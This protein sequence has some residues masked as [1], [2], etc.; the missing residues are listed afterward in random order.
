[1]NNISYSRDERPNFQI[2]MKLY[3]T[4]IH[5]LQEF[6]ANESIDGA[7]S[8]K[9]LILYNFVT[10]CI[11]SEDIQPEL[12]RY[13]LPFYL[14]SMEQAVIYENHD[15]LQKTAMDIYFEFNDAMFFNQK[16]FKYAVGE[17][18]YQYIMEYY[19]SQTL[20]KMEIQNC[21]M[22][23]WVSLFNTTAALDNNNIRRLFHE[24]FKGSLKIKYS[25]F[26]YLSILLF[27]EN[28]N[29]LAINETQEFWTSHIWDFDD[30]YFS[31]K[32]FWNDAIIKFFDREI[33]R[34]RI[35]TLF[36]EIKP[37][38]Y[39]IL[40]P[41]LVELFYEE[42]NESLDSGIFYNRKTEYLKKIN[43][44]SREYIYWDTTF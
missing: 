22:L 15:Y 25:F 20:K 41:K 10:D 26:Q 24:I 36:G 39:H 23:E 14:K 37:F 19:I 29:L 33:N 32:F 4:D 30:G 3:E 44:T 40:E 35:E 2:T 17:K 1:M 12:I 18:N 13:L 21:Y 16:N 31:K 11:Y 9:Y 8:E 7:F 6:I 5:T 27:K 43:D 34:K 42:M 28:D 38:I